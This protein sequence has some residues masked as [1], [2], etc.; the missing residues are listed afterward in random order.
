MRE[1]LNPARLN[2]AIITDI[3]NPHFTTEPGGP[4]QSADIITK[5][6]PNVHTLTRQAGQQKR[7]DAVILSTPSTTGETLN[8][9]ANIGSQLEPTIRPE[10]IIIIT[11]RRDPNGTREEP[12]IA[13]QF[14]DIIKLRWN[15]H[16][17]HVPDND[18]H[19]LLRI[20]RPPKRPPL[21][22]YRIQR[23]IDKIKS[24]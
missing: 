9:I 5:L 17:A 7:F 13:T 4:W 6:F 11:R 10:H 15:M 24:L 14:S 23:L 16:V 19:A 12:T 8:Q 22:V 21:S 2:V 3:D 20:L 1:Q 18:E